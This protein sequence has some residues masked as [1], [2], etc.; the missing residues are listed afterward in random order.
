VAELLPELVTLTAAKGV[1]AAIDNESWLPRGLARQMRG[2]IEKLGAT[3]VTPKPL[4]SLTESDFG[5][6]R[7]QRIPYHCRRFRI[8]KVFRAAPIKIEIDPSQINI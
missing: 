3:C 6:T 8:C 5:V 7:R 1:I 2:W 4:C